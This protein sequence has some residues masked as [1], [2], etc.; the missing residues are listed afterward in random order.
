MINLPKP[1]QLSMKGNTDDRLNYFHNYLTK[2]V[3]EIEK[4]LSGIKKPGKE[5][6]T[7]SDVSIKNNNVIIHYSDGSKKAIEITDYSE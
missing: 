2:L 1:S 7:V 3:Y 6:K 4:A 5:S